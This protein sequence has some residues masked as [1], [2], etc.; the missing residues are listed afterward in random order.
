MAR[1]LRDGSDTPEHRAG[2][3]VGAAF[4]QDLAQHARRRSGDLHR[5]LV[6]FELDQGVVLLDPIADLPQPGADHRLGSF[7]LG[8]DEDFDHRQNPTSSS[9]FARIFSTLG[10][11]QLSSTGLGGLGMSG[12]APRAPGASRSKKPS[13][14]TFAAIPAPN[15]PVL[16]SSWTIRQRRVRRT[17][18]RTISLSHGTR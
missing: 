17:L 9:I 8:G 4:E 5:H 14:A 7:L 11:A 12:I 16:R 1:D 13:P 3:G 15:P 2:H 18:S 6:G 10:T